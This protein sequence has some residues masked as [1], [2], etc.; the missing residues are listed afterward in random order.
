MVAS[1]PGDCDGV[2]TLTGKHGGVGPEKQ[3]KEI[4]AAADRK[5]EEEV[6]G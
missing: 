4:K 2:K 6:E 1:S 5:Q 3:L